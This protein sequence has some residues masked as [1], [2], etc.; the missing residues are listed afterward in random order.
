MI[1]SRLEEDNLTNLHG[2][3]RHLKLNF[4]WLKKEANAGRQALAEKAV[5]SWVK[6]EDDQCQPK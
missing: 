4:E 3:A 6:P 5:I 1:N 2:L